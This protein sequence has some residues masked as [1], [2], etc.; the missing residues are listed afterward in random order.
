MSRHTR[1][2][3]LKSKLKARTLSLLWP[4]SR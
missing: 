3:I 4:T 1:R 2:L